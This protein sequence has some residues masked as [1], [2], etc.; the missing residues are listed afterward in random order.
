M[1]S[2]EW[3]FK[4]YIPTLQ[5][6]TT[7]LMVLWCACVIGATIWGANNGVISVDYTPYSPLLLASAS[8]GGVFSVSVLVG[9]VCRW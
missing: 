9:I 5:V 3:Y 1:G 6:I 7:L 8:V 2:K 4:Y